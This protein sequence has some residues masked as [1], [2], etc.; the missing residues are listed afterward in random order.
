MEVA[1]TR[2]GQWLAGAGVAE[3]E[4]GRVL[5]SVVETLQPVGAG[6]GAPDTGVTLLLGRGLL[7]VESSARRL[8]IYGRNE[9]ATWGRV[10]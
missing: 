8:S 9:L 4:W 5:A 7:H 3:S 1:V 6:P 2:G 10:T